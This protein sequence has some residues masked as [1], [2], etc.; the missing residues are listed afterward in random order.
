MSL[1][2]SVTNDLA[3]QWTSMFFLYIETKT[4][5]FF[6]YIWEGYQHPPKRHRFSYSPPPNQK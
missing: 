1:G 3:N 5:K 2:L 6:K 4:A